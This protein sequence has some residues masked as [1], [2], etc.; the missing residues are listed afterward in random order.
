[1]DVCMEQGL[2]VPAPPAIGP[3]VDPFEAYTARYDA[4]FDEHPSAYQSELG[5]IKAVMPQ[6]E[7]G[8]EIGVGTGRFASPLGIRVGIEPSPAMGRLARSRGVWVG[9]GKAERLPLRDALFDV[10]LLVTALSFVPDVQ[11]ALREARRVLK[12]GGVLIVG[13]IDR[14]SPLGQ[15]YDRHKA[16][17]PLTRS[18]RFLTADELG[19][20]VSQAGFEQLAVAQTIFRNPSQLVRPDPVTPG[21][22]EGLFVVVRATKAG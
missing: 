3:S 14:G 13:E 9:A 12:A 21:C 20:A 18:A 4:W 17:S 7:R 15:A 6:F 22:G 11:Q 16:E 1:M 2:I 8:L 5:A 10:V 19:T